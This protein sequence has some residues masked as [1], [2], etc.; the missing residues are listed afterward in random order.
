VKTDILI[1]VI[2]LCLAL[3]L[4]F[5]ALGALLFLNFRERSRKKSKRATNVHVAP[6]R[7]FLSGFDDDD[8]D[9]TTYATE[10]IPKVA[11]FSAHER[12]MEYRR[13]GKSP[14]G[15]IDGVYNDMNRDGDRPY[16]DM[17]RDWDADA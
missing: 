7:S 1:E 8:K 2:V 12:K 4:F 17:D 5:L 13:R 15:V 14:S 10:D 16:S 6:H 3:L 9:I 11:L